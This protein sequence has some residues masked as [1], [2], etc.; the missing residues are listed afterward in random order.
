MKKNFAVIFIL[1]ILLFNC[2]CE[3]IILKKTNTVSAPFKWPKGEL[4][5]QLYKIS[6][7]EN[8]VDKEKFY[9]ELD[10]FVTKLYLYKNK[11]SIIF[12]EKFLKDY[13]NIKKGD[14]IY[15]E[16]LFYKVASSLNGDEKTVL[17]KITNK[18]IEKYNNTVQEY[19][20]LQ[21]FF[22]LGILGELNTFN[23]EQVYTELDKEEIINKVKLKRIDLVKKLTSLNL[24]IVSNLEDFYGAKN[25]KKDYK[26]FYMSKDIIF[27]KTC[28]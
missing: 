13:E 19:L 1:G 3:K 25:Q 10:I 8:I 5:V 26:S 23:E 28:I 12:D 16:E 6:Y 24:E 21:I 4:K 11:E 15:G 9:N 22:W 20:N 2:G 27:S 14:Y 7:P 17:R 18:N